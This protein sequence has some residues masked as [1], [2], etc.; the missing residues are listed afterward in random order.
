[1]RPPAAITGT[2]LLP[3]SRIV[4]LCLAV[5][6]AAGALT[7]AA[8]ASRRVALGVSMLQD[9]DIATYDAFKAASG[10]APATW[11]IWADW[12]TPSNR[13]LP[14]EFMQYLKANGTVPLVIWQ[15]VD[16][17]DKWNRAYSY[18]NIAKGMYDPYIER[19]AQD[20]RSLDMRVLIR[21]AHEFDGSWY[22]W[23]VGKP[24]NEVNHFRAAW[25]HVYQKFRDAKTGLA[26]QAR[27]I[28][29]PQGSKGAS[30]MKEAFPGSSYV[31][32][33]GFT[34]FNWAGFK[35]MEWR[36]LANIVER[37]VNLFKYLPRK[38]IIVAET[39][40]DYRHKRHTKA[41]WLSDGYA[42]VYKKWPRIV[43]ISYFNVDMRQTGDP[44]HPENWSLDRPTDGS[45]MR[46]YRALLKQTKFK[47]TVN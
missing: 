23:G 8:A 14:L 5:L 1:M 33:L 9:R 28:W 40:T 20:L 25:R 18:R 6:L 22:P 34:A 29:S 42:A 47:G 21:F 4:T 39:G 26:K 43:A 24:G 35:K 32:Y 37:R 31:D 45:P 15:P 36:S 46:A 7:P 12:G 38:P 44:K 3:L 19:F 10:R 13:D 27:F 16:S 41:K 11:S 2:R 17:R 30:W